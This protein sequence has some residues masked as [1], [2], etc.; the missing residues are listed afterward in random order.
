VSLLD[1]LNSRT[2]GSSPLNFNVLVKGWWDS[3]LVTR[4]R[5]QQLRL[6]LKLLREHLRVWSKEIFG[7]V[8]ARK[9]D[10][11]KDINLWDSNEV[12]GNLSKV[13]RQMWDLAKQ[14][15]EHTTCL[16]EIKWNQKAK[17]K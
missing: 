9:K 1:H 6:K 4:K 13:Q 7:N 15:C 16:E 5:S 8:E 3:F 12:R 11:L 10:L 14:D 17:V 2:C